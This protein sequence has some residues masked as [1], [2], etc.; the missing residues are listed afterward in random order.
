MWH[1]NKIHQL[2]KLIKT[3]TSE[4]NIEQNEVCESTNLDKKTDKNTTFIPEKSIEISEVDNTESFNSKLNSFNKGEKNYYNSDK[5]NQSLINRIS[6]FSSSFLGK[7]SW[8]RPNL[9]Y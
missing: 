4:A 6:G 2:W 5:E 1:I 8:Y 7:K 9:D 3:E